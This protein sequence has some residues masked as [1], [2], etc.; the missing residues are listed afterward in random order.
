MVPDH[1]IPLLRRTISLSKNL[2]PCKPRTHA[3]CRQ[4]SPKE[5]LNLANTPSQT[6]QS[7]GR[8]MSWGKK[9]GNFK[10]NSSSWKPEEYG[11]I[12]FLIQCNTKAYWF[13]VQNIWHSFLSISITSF[14]PQANI[15]SYL[16][17]C[18]SLLT[19]LSIDWKHP[20]SPI[21]Y[22]FSTHYSCWYFHNANW[23]IIFL[24]ISPTFPLTLSSEH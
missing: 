10:E 4:A 12:P 22:L 15:I 6:H 17:L 3:P 9:P 5:G 1:C 2:T 23:I 21:F 18:N 16:D 11:S 19:I 8:S 24:P 7:C 13:H 14:L 20:F